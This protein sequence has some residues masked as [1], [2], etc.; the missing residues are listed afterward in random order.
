MPRSLK[1]EIDSET[2]NRITLLN[3][4]DY[5]SYLKKELTQWKKNPRTETNPDGVWLHPEDVSGNMQA[6]EALNLIIKHFGG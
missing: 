3:L 4:K 5:Q 1:L 2:A 6:I